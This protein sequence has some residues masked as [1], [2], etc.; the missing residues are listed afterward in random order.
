METERPAAA[1][2]Q[3]FETFVSSHRVRAHRLAWR[4][5]GGDAQ[6]EDVVQ[7]AFV[8][9]YRALDRFRDDSNLSTWFYRIL[10]NEAHRF[11]R[12]RGVRERWHALWAAEPDAVHA[13]THGDPAVRDRIANA[14]DRLS[15]SQREVFILIHLEGMTIRDTAE[16][17]EKAEGTV[18]SHL[19]RALQV[20]RKELS[21]LAPQGGRS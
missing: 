17:L 14:L 11:N 8:K 6:A 7:E 21:D 4:L 2:A 18:K 9:A 1:L 3:R 5:V 10:V 19:H 20:L 15:R 12:W 13:D 16:V